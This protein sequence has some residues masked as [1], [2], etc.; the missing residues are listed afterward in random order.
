MPHLLTVLLA[1]AQHYDAKKRLELHNVIVRMLVH[2]HVQNR[3]PQDSHA[4]LCE[5]CEMASTSSLES[6]LN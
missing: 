6:T 2:S 5:T 4:A 1:R 3:V